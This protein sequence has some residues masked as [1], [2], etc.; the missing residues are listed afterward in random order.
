M[1]RPAACSAS[2]TSADRALLV[3]V[4]I[5]LEGT[6]IA[7]VVDWMALFAGVVRDD[8]GDEGDRLWWLEFFLR[9][10]LA[11]AS[12]HSLTTSAKREG[13]RHTVTFAAILNT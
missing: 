5:A 10:I 6:E 12:S 11:I 3:E 13:I 8:I 9:E 4:W 7:D 2:L 1:T